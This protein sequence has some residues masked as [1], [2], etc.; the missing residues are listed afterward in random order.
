[1]STEEIIKLLKR[2]R[3]KYIIIICLFV[4]ISMLLIATAFIAIFNDNY[5]KDGTSIN[6]VDCS[7]MSVQEAQKAVEEKLNNDVVHLLLPD[8][9]IEIVAS[10][11]EFKLQEDELSYFLEQQKET[12]QLQFEASVTL[13]KSLI[14]KKLSGE[15][16]FSNAYLQ[17]EDDNLFEIIPESGY[18]MDTDSAVEKAYE[19]LKSGAK[20]I[21]LK[22]LCDFPDVVASKLVGEQEKLNTILST[23]ITFQ[24]PDNIICLDKNVIKDWIVKDGNGNFSIDVEANLPLFIQKLNE[25]STFTVNKNILSTDLGVEIY[26]EKITVELDTD[27]ELMKILSEIGTTVKHELIYKPY[28]NMPVDDYVEIDLGRQN[29]WMYID[30]KCI[31]DTPCVTGSVAGGHA[32]PPGVFKLKSKETKRYLQGY[33]NDGSKYKSYVN[34]W[35][36]FNGGIGL[37]D[38]TWRNKFGGNIYKNSGSHGCVN[39]PLSAARTIYEN[40][41]YDMP[42]IVYDSENGG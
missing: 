36:P 17:L 28:D 4:I 12:G 20:V 18:S 9:T 21:D 25:L 16:T 19:E 35:M 31:V 7:K 29:V 41:D 34:Y 15:Y 13:N 38:A 24:L 6:G 3:K 1:M 22:T 27:A 10:D 2:R 40:I 14:T 30:G 26:A 23:N 5:F 32:T 37:H 42:I 39:L 33:N 11:L 8:E